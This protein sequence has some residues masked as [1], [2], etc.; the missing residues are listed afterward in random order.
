MSKTLHISTKGGITGNYK[1]ITTA[2]KKDK[3]TLKKGKSFKLKAKAVPQN[4]ILK[5]RNHRK[6]CY[7]SSNTKIAKVSKTGKITAKKKGKC[8]VYV[9]AQSGT[10]KKIKVSVSSK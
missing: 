9:Y 3:V 10:F 4:K 2:A 7:E 6:L 5:V 8:F 1:K